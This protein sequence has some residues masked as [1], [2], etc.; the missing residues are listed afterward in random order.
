M[1]QPSGTQL[2]LGLGLLAAVAIL[3]YSMNS[4]HQP[5]AA[6]DARKG[7]ARPPAPT[8]AA[9]EEGKAELLH[10]AAPSDADYG[11]YEMVADRNVF[12]PP[13]PPPPRPARRPSRSG[14]LPPP[15]GLPSGG[16]LIVYDPFGNPVRP[17]DTGPP[18]PPP[19]RTLTGW[20]YAG[21]LRVDETS[22][23]ILQSESS[24][25]VREAA[26]G[27]DFQGF[28][29]ESVSGDEIV[30]SAGGSRTTLKRPKEYPMIPLGKSATALPRAARVTRGGGPAE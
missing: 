18:P 25:T 13:Q 23:G 14:P 8:G 7:E 17:P 16:P 30:L 3:V 10:Q 26:V 24:S 20:S 11:R 2:R 29:V 9:R 5:P 22:Y 28:R 21:Y 1:K 27:S 4:G 15:L 19:V 6:V 12:A